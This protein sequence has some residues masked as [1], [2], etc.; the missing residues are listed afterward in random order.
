MVSEKSVQDEIR[1]FVVECCGFAHK[2][3][4]SAL[5]GKTTLDLLGG[6]RGYPFVCEV[7]RPGE[8]PTKYQLYE[9]DRFRA[10]GYIAIWADSLAMFKHKF[11]YAK[12]EKEHHAKSRTDTIVGPN[13]K[14]GDNRT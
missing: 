12:W 2:L 10:G 11:Y 7:K 8:C 5:S 6:W 9:L 13:L 1:E 14:S 4:G 3:H